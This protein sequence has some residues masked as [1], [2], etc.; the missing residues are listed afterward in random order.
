VGLR[1][2]ID[3]KNAE[4]KKILIRSVN[5]IGDA[6]LTTPAV[7]S[8]RKNFPQ[9][10]ISI[11]AK[12][13]VSEIFKRNPDIDEI[14]LYEGSGLGKRVRLIKGLRDKGFDLAVLFQ[15]AFEAALISF[16]SGIPIR[17]GYST[18]GRGFLL[19]PSLPVKAETLKRHHLEYYLYLLKE[20]GLKVEECPLVLNINEMERS[21]AINFLKDRGWKEGDI[22]IGINPGATYGSAKRWYPERFASL[23]DRLMKEG[24]KVII[25]GGPGENAI[26][27]EIKDHSRFTVHGSRLIAAGKTTVRELASLIERCSVFVSNDTGPMHMAAA[28]K[29]SVV[30]LF[31]STDPNATGPIGEGH[32]IIQKRVECGPCFLRVCPKDF[33]CMNLITVDDVFY[34]VK[35][36]LENEP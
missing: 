16:L 19:K 27:E 18:D 30:A 20:A 14:I 28:L 9:A 33:S 17:L 29:V 5:W 3:F 11:L 21:W 10:T 22:L 8:I 6:I 7:S 4:I 35:E 15:N 31:G 13:W 2:M 23:T 26:V 36:V 25:F 1:E 34:A 12:P 24:L 32:K